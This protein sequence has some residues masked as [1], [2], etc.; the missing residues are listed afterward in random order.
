MVC[1]K[2]KRRRP[3]GTGR[4]RA[5]PGPHRPA[6]T[7]GCRS[8]ASSPSTSATRAPGLA[9][10][11]WTG[12]IACRSAHRRA[13]RGEGRRRDPRTGRAN[14]RRRSSSS[15]CRWPSTARRVHARSA[16]PRS[17]RGCRQA[18][19]CP[20]HAVDESHSTDEAHE[21]LKEGGLKASGAR[22]SPT[23]SPPGDPRA[24]PRRSCAAGPARERPRALPDVP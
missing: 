2:D 15:A 6:V 5:R 13:R 23:A 1:P 7:D 19:P 22:T 10:T 16:P 17:A 20:V 9:A 14:A 24:L 4:T 21:R 12:T 18:L 11:D 3:E 8:A